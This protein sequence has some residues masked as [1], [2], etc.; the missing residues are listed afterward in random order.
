MFQSLL[1]LILIVPILTILCIG[2][3]QVVLWVMLYMYWK[4]DDIVRR[5]GKK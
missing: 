3:L 1:F 4:I 2:L 5:L